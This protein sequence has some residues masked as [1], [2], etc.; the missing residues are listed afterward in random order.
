MSINF[1]R[2]IAILF[3]G[4]PF[5]CPS[6]NTYNARV[7]RLLPG[8]TFGFASG[9]S[10]LEP[11]LG[12]RAALC[13]PSLRRA[14]VR[15]PHRV[16]LCVHRLA[17]LLPCEP[18]SLLDAGAKIVGARRVGFWRIPIRPQ[19]SR[20]DVGAPLHM[21]MAITTYERSARKSAKRAIVLIHS[22]SSGS[23]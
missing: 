16:P 14:L 1:M 6:H 5:A 18:N 3:S 22:R 15:S 10:V 23:R 17:A 21:G 12:G 20:A 13:L 9:I 2:R 4:I 8:G 19:I 11:K 7:R